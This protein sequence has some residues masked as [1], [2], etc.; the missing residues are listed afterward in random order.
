MRGN[1]H[2]RF[3]EGLGVRKDP[4]L[5]GAVTGP[6]EWR[7]KKMIEFIVLL[8]VL[9]ICFGINALDRRPVVNPGRAAAIALTILAL[10]EMAAVIL[11]P[12]STNGRAYQLGAALGRAI[13]PLIIALYISQKLRLA[14]MLGLDV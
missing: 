13:V 2:V 5:L 6:E 8:L 1:S 4:S 7:G 10:I 9:G 3:L 14:P 11:M 12:S